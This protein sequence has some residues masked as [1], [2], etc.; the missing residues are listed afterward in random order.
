MPGSLKPQELH[1]GK[2]SGKIIFPQQVFQ[3]GTADMVV[4]EVAD[5]FGNLRA[6]IFRFIQNTVKAQEFPPIP[7]VIHNSA[8]GKPCMYLFGGIGGGLKIYRKDI[9]AWNLIDKP[10]SPDMF[11]N[12]ECGPKARGIPGRAGGLYPAKSMGE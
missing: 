4:V 5:Q 1:W 12:S 6:K 7:A 8:T 2:E 10:G 11:L 9:F 3:R